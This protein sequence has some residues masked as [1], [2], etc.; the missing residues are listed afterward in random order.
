MPVE[1]AWLKRQPPID[2]PDR[3]VVLRG[4]GGCSALLLHGLTGSPAELGYLAFYLQRR[5]RAS[6]RAPALAN[7]G[8][9]LAV[10]AR[11]TR[12]ELYESVKAAFVEARRDARERGVPLVVGGL[13]IGANLA[14]MLAS[15]FPEDV[16]GVACLS[17]TLFYDGWNV[18]WSRRLLAFARYTPFKYFTYFR[19]SPPFGL[20]DEALRTRIGGQFEKMSLRESGAAAKL[21]YAHF[22][23]RL[24]CEM[25][26]L[27]ERCKEILPRVSC[28]VLLLQAEEDDMTSPRNSRFIYDRLGSARRELV[29]LRDSYHVIT[30]DQ[31][32]G[33]V[34]DHVQKFCESLMQATR[35]VRRK[36]AASA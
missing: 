10:L 15:D 21:G 16:A 29:L 27:I 30:A 11:T 35:P 18:P 22:P 24:F 25:Q 20:K 4:D 23:V 8:Q 19:E 12:H 1:W 28:P 2:L 31:E 32:R 13:S 17:P 3:D 36:V 33:A 7:H 9:P 5:A 14:L 34:A 6:V 26:P